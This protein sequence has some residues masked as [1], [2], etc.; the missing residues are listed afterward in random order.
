MGSALGLFV[1]L[2]LPAQAQQTQVDVYRLVV[3]SYQSEVF[4]I[5][6]A[7]QLANKGLTVEVIRVSQ[8]TGIRH[9]LVYG[10]FATLKETET[11]LKDLAS[12]YNLR[13][14]WIWKLV[15]AGLLPTQTT[16]PTRQD[17][18]VM[19]Q[20][21]TI[22]RRDTVYIIAAP[23]T[24]ETDTLRYVTPDGQVLQT[25]PVPHSE[26]RFPSVANPENDGL[27]LAVID[28]LDHR[29]QV[30]FDAYVD[31]YYASQNRAPLP[32]GTTSLNT[33]GL[34]N[35]QFG[36][37]TAQISAKLSGN[38]YRAIVTLHAGD[39]RLQGWDSYT[40]QGLLQQ[41]NAGIR[42]SKGVWV[43]AGFF[44]THIGGEAILPR[45]NWISSLALVTFF[46][47]FIQSGMKLTLDISPKLQLQLHGLNGYNVYED[48]NKSLSGGWLVTW[49][50]SDKFTTYFS[51]IVG[52]EQPSDSAS[53]IRQYYNLVFVL[54]ATNWLGFKAQGDVGL[55]AA[56]AN[57]PERQMMGGQFTVKT[58]FT[59]KTSLALRVEYYDDVDAVVSPGIVGWGGTAQIEYKP[60][61]NSFLRLEG[62][63]FNLEQPA[64]FFQE[65][66]SSINRN[67]RLQWQ[68]G[69]G[70]WL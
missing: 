5:A 44:M 49:L 10:R 45:D 68:L 40:S 53:S 21:D 36:I 56:T 64:G 8:P 16:Q 43:D 27:V 62:R 57:R 3:G 42:L 59:P 24:A 29:A 34:R 4:A 26:S 70:V 14:T 25:V 6:S 50:A 69:I 18:L 39:V 22:V 9:R 12:R 17:T 35:Q 19:V 47:P 31:A 46:E 61:K 30:S 20:R 58:S 67:S 32:D 66:S 13:D 51:G 37:N 48:N 2:W 15:G 33:V 65:T 28:S 23:G 38:Q 7:Q 63:Y 55:E 1:L 52:N 54:Q 60:T 41:A 11:A